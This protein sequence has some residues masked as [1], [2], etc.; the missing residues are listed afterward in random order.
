[1]DNHSRR[2]L[3]RAAGLSLQ[4]FPHPQLYGQIRTFTPE[5]AFLLIQKSGLGRA[6]IAGFR[7]ALERGY[8]YI[9]EMDAD[10]S[11]NPADV[12]RLR[13]AAASS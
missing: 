4:L 10:F 7:W 2:G 9:L 13:A 6:Y 5:R 1:M 8:E 11:H 3:N 12:P